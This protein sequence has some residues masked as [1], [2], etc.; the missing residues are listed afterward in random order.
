MPLAGL[1]GEIARARRQAALGYL[2]NASLSIAEVA[3]LLGYSETSAFH[4]AFKR[5]E[6]VTPQA[7]RATRRASSVILPQ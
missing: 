7:W 3:W 1:E 6:R 5:W 4:R 2:R